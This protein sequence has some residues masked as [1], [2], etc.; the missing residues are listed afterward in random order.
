MTEKKRLRAVSPGERADP[1]TV[2]EAAM[3]GDR[4]AELRAMRRVIARALDSD[5][6]LARDLASLSRRQ[7]ELGKEIEALEAEQAEVSREAEVARGE[8]ST[9]WKPEAI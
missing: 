9:A 6:T 4:L 3:Q 8:V 1:Q 7:M 5:R 2:S